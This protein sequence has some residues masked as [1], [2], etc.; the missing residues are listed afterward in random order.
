MKVFVGMETSGVVRRAFIAAGH[1][2]VSCD[3]LDA[4]DG[5]T[6]PLIGNEFSCGHIVGDVF[7][8]LPDLE[9]S[10]W[11]PDLAIFHP[12]CTYF[13]V[14]AA[15]AFKDPDFERYP[16]VGYHM[17]LKEGT[18]TGQARRDRQAE[19][20]KNIKK[21]QFLKI[22]TKVVENPVGSLSK[23][24]MTPSDIVQPYE[25]GDDASKKT[26]LWVLDEFGNKVDRKFSR[27]PMSLIA[28][29]L[30]ENGKSYW[31]NQTDN[32]QNKLAP[33]ENRWQVRSD[34]YPGIAN[35]LVS[36]LG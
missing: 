15:W 22:K 5:A 11:I 19:D 13:T 17:K 30:R 31:S 27:N 3:L 9:R 24:W 28:P 32:G 1:E 21:I 10:G 2:V 25:F 33:S 36:E 6:P 8:V 26:C 34:T 35:A 16:G 18:L 20:L 14:S 4:Q 12:D 7:K 23:L 29:T